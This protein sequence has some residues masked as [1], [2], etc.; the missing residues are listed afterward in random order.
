MACCSQ[1]AGESSVVVRFVRLRVVRATAAFHKG[2]ALGMACRQQAWT[3]NRV[4]QDLPVRARWRIDFSVV[5]RLRIVR[6]TEAFH[7]GRCPRN[8]SVVAG[9]HA[10]SSSAGLAC[11]SSVVGGERVVAH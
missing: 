6:A 4:P 1:T 7:E 10:T 5:V 9:A 2:L 8:G 11:Q 3:P